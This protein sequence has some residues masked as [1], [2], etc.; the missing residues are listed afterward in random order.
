MMPRPCGI[1]IFL[2]G[3]EQHLHP[4][5]DPEERTAGCGGVERRLFEPDVSQRIHARAE[6]PHPRQHDPCRLSDQSGVSSEPG[7]GAHP[8]DRL[9]GRVQ[10]AD[11]VVEHGHQRPLAGIAHGT[12]FTAHY[13]FHG[14]TSQHA[15][16]RR[17]TA[18]AVDSH[19]VAQ[20]R[21]PDP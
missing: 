17:D 8:F 14:T 15:F 9:L 2:A 16:G 3:S 7:V 18:V 11:P 4:D 13:A 10:V 19:G 1:R 5:A 21:A 6:R 12:P 20:R